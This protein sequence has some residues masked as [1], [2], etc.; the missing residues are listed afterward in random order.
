MLLQQYVT[1]KSCIFRWDNKTKILLSHFFY[2]IIMQKEDYKFWHIIYP[3]D[4]F[5]RNVDILGTYEN[6]NEAQRNL[7]QLKQEYSSCDCPVK[8]EMALRL[9]VRGYMYN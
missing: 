2:Y 1:Q 6:Y 5:Y 3:K 7:A 4:N 9:E 8:K